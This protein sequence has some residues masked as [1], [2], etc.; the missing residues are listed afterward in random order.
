MNAE[1]V[2]CGHRGAPVAAP[3]NRIAAMHAAA[4]RGA[5]WVE[6]DVRPAGDDVLVVHHDPVTSD[7]RVIAET[8]SGE[9]ADVAD[10]FE[11]LVGATALGLDVEVKTDRTGR[12]TDVLAALVAAELN[13][14]VPAER[15]GGSM[16]VTSFDWA[17]L[18]ALRL[19]A[20][21][22]ETGLLFMD[23]RLV[24]AVAAATSG[25]H[26]VVAPWHGLV[27][28]AAVEAA[29]D[30]GLRVATWTV[31]QPADI[32]RV[33]SAGVDM[34]IGNDPADIVAGIAAASG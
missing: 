21:A 2:V 20:P 26:S 1:P 16:V 30:A 24:D 10:T 34:I 23:R 25:G 13:A 9:L 33:I 27:S 18:D 6:F 11:A 12:D 17:F 31:N 19:I 15:L 5:T 4:D 32:A 22:F 28:A 3:E 14:Y 8:P 7:G 29:H